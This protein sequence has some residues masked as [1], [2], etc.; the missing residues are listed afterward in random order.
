MAESP[1]PTWPVL[2]NQPA[3]FGEVASTPTAW[4]TLAAID[5]AVLAADRAARAQARAAAWAAGMDPG[6]YVIDFDGTLVH[7]HSE[8][9]GAA[10]TYKRGFG[11]HPLLVYLDAT[12]EA[13]AGDAPARQ[14]RF[15][16]HR[17]SCRAC[18]TPPWPSCRSTRTRSR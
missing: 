12:G 2:R 4:R 14:R 1:S 16:H 18:S 11:F 9:Q 13:L 3:L 17:R 8:K 10:P 5:D 15:E 7:S 6:F